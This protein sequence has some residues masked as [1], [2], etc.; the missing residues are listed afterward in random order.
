MVQRDRGFQIPI[1]TIIT[2]AGG[3]ADEIWKTHGPDVAIRDQIKEVMFVNFMMA[4]KGVGGK[5]AWRASRVFR[6]Y[7]EQRLNELRSE[8]Q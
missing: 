6:Y 4:W 3:A 7:L 2:Y 8:R 1:S 5:D